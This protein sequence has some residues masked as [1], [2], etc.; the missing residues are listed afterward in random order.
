MG[1]EKHAST[2]KPKQT[3]TARHF[4]SLNERCIDV[5]SGEHLL[6]AWMMLPGE[7]R[8]LSV[9]TSRM[10]GIEQTYAGYRDGRRKVGDR[11]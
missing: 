8:M 10:G 6:G 5:H 7:G 1:H 11:R 3:P 2:H 4:G 9:Q